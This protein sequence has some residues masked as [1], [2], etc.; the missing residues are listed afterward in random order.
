[1]KQEDLG[2]QVITQQKEGKAKYELHRSLKPKYEKRQ[3]KPVQRLK[4]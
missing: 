1:L 3:T 2:H 4:Y